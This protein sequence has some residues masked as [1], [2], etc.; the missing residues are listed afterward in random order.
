MGNLSLHILKKK[1]GINQ[2]SKFPLKNL[3]GRKSKAKRN[4][5]MEENSKG[6]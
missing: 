4:K 1:I 6:Q 2:Y 3:G 5:K